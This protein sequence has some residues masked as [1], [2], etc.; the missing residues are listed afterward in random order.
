[1]A[2]TS[3][4]QGVA[5]AQRDAA[6]AETDLNICTYGQAKFTR[7]QMPAA[8]MTYTGGT[9]EN[10]CSQC[11]DVVTTQVWAIYGR[12]PDEVSVIMEQLMWLWYKTAVRAVLTPLGFI[13]FTLV[14]AVPAQLIQGTDMAG[15]LMGVLEFEVRLRI[16]NPY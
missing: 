12:D 10:Y 14:D 9:P 16:D 5:D 6:V 15:A 4:F 3:V 1:M 13:G 11:L 2:F 8:M 7:N